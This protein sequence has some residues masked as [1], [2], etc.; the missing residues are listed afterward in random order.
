M[1]RLVDAYDAALFDLDG[2]VYRG[3]EAV[4]A[5]PP[6]FAELR[7]SGV[8]VGFVT[9]NAARSAGSVATHLRELGIEADEPDVVTSAQAACRLLVADLGE[10]ARVLVTGTQDLVA[11]VEAS[12][13]VPVAAAADQPAAVLCGFAPRLTWDELNE[14]C[15]AV[16]RG[17]AW[18]ACNPDLTRPTVEGVAIGMGGM[19]AAMSVALPG[20]TPIVAGK[21]QRPLL[22]ETVRRLGARR[23]IFVGDR[24]DTD[25][26][27]ARAAGM[28]SLLVLSGTHQAA[29]LLA[30]APQHRPTYVADD[31]AGL[32][33]PPLVAVPVVTLA[34][35]RLT[36]TDPGTDRLHLMWSAAQLVWEAADRGVALD[37]S[38]VLAVIERR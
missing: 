28:D 9:N 11:E 25:I 13:L 14:A 33:Q 29:D 4:P 24:L 27:G 26:E 18:Y 31:V 16:Q 37:V 3:L 32:L 10:G 20:R 35:D 34:E 23:P 2:V 19:L 38:E 6:T 5:A 15:F 1:S 21:P 36:V 8:T 17:A 12:G 7:R 30:A 22:D